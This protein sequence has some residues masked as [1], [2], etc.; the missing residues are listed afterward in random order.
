MRQSFYY[1]TLGNT[2]CIIRFWCRLHNI[3]TQDF[4]LN[5]NPRVHPAD[6]HREVILNIITYQIVKGI[7]CI[8][9]EVILCRDAKV[10]TKHQ[11]YFIIFD[12]FPAL[13]SKLTVRFYILLALQMYPRLCILSPKLWLQQV[14][15]CNKLEHK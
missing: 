9:A 5:Y 11:T 15:K 4:R 14:Q 12:L 2:V 1:S 7:F 3:W 6:T 10:Y 8:L 13:I